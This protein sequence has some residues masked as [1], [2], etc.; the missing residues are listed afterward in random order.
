MMRVVKVGITALLVAA[1]ACSASGI[2]VRDTG[3]VGDGKA[4]DTAA[5]QE[6]IARA[7]LTGETVSVPQG[8]YRIK[9]TLELKS[10]TL[11]GADVAAWVADESCLPVIIPQMKDG[12]CIRLLAGGSVHGLHFKYEWPAD[13]PSP[14]PATVELAGVGCRVSELKIHGAWD[15]I[16]ADGKNNVGRALVERCFIV[17]VHHVGVR[18][19]GTWDV[20]W[21]SKVEVWSPASTTFPRS[22]V[23]FLLGKNDVL[24]M[25]DCFSFRAAM[26]YQF[27]D[28]IPGCEI[29]GGT[30]GSLSNCASDL[31]SRGVVVSG[32]HTISLVGGT[33]W[34][35]FG[36]L[37]IEGKGGQ[38]RV[39]GAELAANGAPAL[40]IS[41]GDVVAVT[42]CQIRRTHPGFDAPAMRITGG[43][44]VAVTGCVIVSTT[45]GVEVAEGLERVVL[46][47]NVVR[48]NVKQ[49]EAAN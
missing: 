10:Q 26:G 13:G 17:D 9:K 37:A 8:T 2:S 24:L 41:G 49:D 15:A 48:E 7:R 31:C 35:H 6:A 43:D 1:C 18:V 42:G 25:S 23:G 34:S 3:A 33:H 5:F 22:G 28:E 40:D 4:D 36:G 46:G 12:P 29:K 39:S 11:K 30:W 19:T 47:N 14:T 20:S 16:A 21:I 45:K 32:A 27:L 38:V 44:G